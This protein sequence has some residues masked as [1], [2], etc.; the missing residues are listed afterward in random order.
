[1]SLEPKTIGD[2]IRI[3]LAQC[4]LSSLASYVVGNVGDGN[5]LPVRLVTRAPRIGKTGLG[6]NVTEGHQRL[7][8]GHCRVEAT[9]LLCSRLTHPP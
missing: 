8:S 7:D 6:G 2:A 4:E 3:L 1:M 9:L 5:E